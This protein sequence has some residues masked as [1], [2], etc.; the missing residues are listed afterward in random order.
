MLQEA[1]PSGRSITGTFYKYNVLFKEIEKKKYFKRRP[2]TGIRNICLIRDNASHHKSKNGQDY[3]SVESIEQLSH[4]P[5]SP[6]LSMC[7]LF[8]F[9]RL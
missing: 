3:L 6:D 9:P 7:D 8:L 1:A 2:K 4:P 5:Y